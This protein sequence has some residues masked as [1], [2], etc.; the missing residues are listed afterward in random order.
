MADI[1]NVCGFCDWALYAAHVHWAF[2][3][4]LA[5]SPTPSGRHLLG[6][7]LS[8][9]HIL[10]L[11]PAAEW[12]GLWPKLTAGQYLDALAKNGAVVQTVTE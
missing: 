1:R 3:V 6:R 9:S 8:T 7:L 4:A 11:W 10:L 5:L 2:M 12:L